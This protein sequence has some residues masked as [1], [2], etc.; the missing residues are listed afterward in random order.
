MISVE[1]TRRR[2]ARGNRHPHGAVAAALRHLSPR[3]LQ[4]IRS[5]T[6]PKDAEDQELTQIRIEV[7][8][9]ATAP[10]RPVPPRGEM[11]RERLGEVARG[12]SEG[13]L[14]EELERIA[15]Q[16]SNTRSKM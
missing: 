11:P 6:T 10:K 12:M 16:R 8:V 1:R 3:I 4:A 14:K 15:R 9:S 2:R 13:P 5:G 7:Q